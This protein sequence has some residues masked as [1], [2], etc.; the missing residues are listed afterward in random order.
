MCKN[1]LTPSIV[2][3]IRLYVIYGVMKI[4][5][6]TSTCSDLSS[7]ESLNLT[8][9]RIALKSIQNIYTFSSREIA[10]VADRWYLEN[11]DKPNR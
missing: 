8:K 4:K 1:D 9:V 11:V 10:S 3:V 6:A 7:N 2:N 5:L